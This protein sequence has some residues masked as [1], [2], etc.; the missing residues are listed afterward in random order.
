MEPNLNRKLERKG[1][2][3][4]EGEGSNHVFISQEGIDGDSLL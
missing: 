3:E 4:R 2:A 1:E